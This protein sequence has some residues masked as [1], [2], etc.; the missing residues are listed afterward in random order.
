MTTLLDQS[1]LWPR[2]NT[3][4]P[5]DARLAELLN[6]QCR[7]L[8]NSYVPPVDLRTSNEVNIRGAAM[9][10]YT[11]AVVVQTSVFDPDL[12]GIPSYTTAQNRATAL[13]NGVAAGHQATY[14]PTGG[15]GAHG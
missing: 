4:V 6:G 14:G 7:W 15:A 9:A 2:T 12:S 8:T 5:I 13:V 10:A 3:T 1:E 11:I